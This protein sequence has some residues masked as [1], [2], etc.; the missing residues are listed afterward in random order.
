MSLWSYDLVCQWPSVHFITLLTF[1]LR[2]FLVSYCFCSFCQGY[3]PSTIWSKSRYIQFCYCTLGASDVQGVPHLFHFS[4]LS[5]VRYGSFFM[6]IICA[7]IKFG[8]CRFR[9]I[10]WLHYKLHLELDRF[11]DLYSIHILRY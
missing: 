11:D 6:K 3:K 10:L 7:C 8:Y 4:F 1:E 2:N 5:V 9:M